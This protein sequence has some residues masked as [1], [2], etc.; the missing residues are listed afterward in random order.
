M[1]TYRNNPLKLLLKTVPLY[2]SFKKAEG[3]SR[4]ELEAFQIKK[5]QEITDYAYV[6]V[7]YYHEQY[8]KAGF[9]P[10]DIK[11]LQDF[12]KLPFLEKE[13]LRTLPKE[14]FLSDETPKLDVSYINTSGST[15]IPLSFACDLLARAANYA[16][17]YRALNAAGYRIGDV[18]FILKNLPSLKSVCKFSKFSRQLLMHSYHLEDSS[19]EILTTFLKAHKP[20]HIVAHPNALLEL[21]TRLKNVNELFSKVK[22]ITSLAEVLTPQVRKSLEQIF[23]C[24]VYDYYSNMESSIMA[25]QIENGENIFAEYFCYPEIENPQPDDPLTGELTTTAFY[26][27]AMPLIRYRN[28]DVVS[29]SQAKPEDRSQLLHVNSVCGRVAERVTL[30]SGVTIGLFS[31]LRADLTNVSAYQFVQTSQDSIRIDYIPINNSLPINENSMLYELASY[32]GQEV[33][34]S[35]KQVETLQKNSAGKVPRTIIFKNQ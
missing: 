34:V 23:H 15:G 32:V 14:Q 9:K 25:Y 10:G 18:Q 6:H 22:G 35:I 31:L 3:W 11:S 12:Q 2:R 19:L 28:K 8:Q 33:H 4:D 29:L 16:A 7:P 17:T 24:K 26:S 5:L 1:S 13:A 27:I 30:P 20:K 21:G